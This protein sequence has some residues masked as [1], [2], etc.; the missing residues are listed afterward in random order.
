[1][2]S[3]WTRDIS[4][5]ALSLQARSG[6]LHVTQGIFL[7]RHPPISIELV[8]CHTKMQIEDIDFTCRSVDGFYCTGRIVFVYA[9]GSH[10]IRYEV[11]GPSGMSKYVMA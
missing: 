8:R 2:C 7:P 5:C 9:T 6:S 11:M 4:P 3:H 1:M 10:G